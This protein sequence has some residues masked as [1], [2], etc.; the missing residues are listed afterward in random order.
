MKKNA[1][2]LQGVL[3]D[4]NSNFLKSIKKD[5]LS[6]KNYSSNMHNEAG[7]NIAKFIPKKDINNQTASICTKYLKEI[8]AYMQKR[9]IEKK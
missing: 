5:T 4:I 7:A 2:L 9:T 1:I 8:F 3:T 6:P